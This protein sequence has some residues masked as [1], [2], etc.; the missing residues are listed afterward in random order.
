MPA[1]H[2]AV[3]FSYGV[4]HSKG[5]LKSTLLKPFSTA[6]SFFFRRPVGRSAG[7]KGMGLRGRARDGGSRSHNRRARRSRT[8]D[9]RGRDCAS[10]ASRVVLA[11]IE[12]AAIDIERPSPPMIGRAGQIRPSGASR[13]SI[14]AKSGRTL[15]AAIARAIARSAAPRMLKASISSTLANTI[16]TLSALA[17]MIF[18]ERFARGRRERLRNRR[19]RPADRRDRE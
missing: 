19:P 8:A 10:S 4:S 18:A 1:A 15:K 14:S 17:K 3:S 16:E 5:Y 9:S 12:A 13:P 2:A 7:D 11:T 6:S